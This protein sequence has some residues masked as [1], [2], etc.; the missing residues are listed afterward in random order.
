MRVGDEQWASIS[1]RCC[2]ELVAIDQAY[3]GLDRIDIESSEGDV[4]ERHRRQHDALDALVGAQ[5][6]NRAFQHQRR[7]RHGVEDLAVLGGR[8]DEAFGDLGVHIGKRVARLVDIVEGGGV[9]DQRGTRV[10]RR[11]DETT[12][13]AVDRVERLLRDV[14]G[15]CRAEPDDR[16]PRTSVGHDVSGTTDSDSALHRPYRGST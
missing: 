15:A 8:G 5:A 3:T 6:S 2:G 9:G 13:R 10:T 1:G 12:R 16:D 14:L 7:A 4:E 11:S